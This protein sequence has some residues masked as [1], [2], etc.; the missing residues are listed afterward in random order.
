MAYRSELDGRGRERGIAELRRVYIAPSHRGNGLGRRMVE[1]LIATDHSLMEKT[2]LRPE[3]INASRVPDE[4]IASAVSFNEVSFRLQRKVFQVFQSFGGGFASLRLR[5]VGFSDCTDAVGAVRKARRVKDINRKNVSSIPLFLNYVPLSM[6]VR[7][8]RS[9]LQ[10]RLT[11]VPVRRECPAEWPRSPRYP[12]TSM[13]FR[14]VPSPRSGL[15]GLP[16][17]TDCHVECANRPLG[18]GMRSVLQGATLH[19]EAALSVPPLGQSPYLQVPH[20]T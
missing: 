7:L 16:A 8:W 11:P 18:L 10:D 9:H 14:Y 3:A 19:V 20:R 5:P 17:R 15:F 13:Q 4:T 2:M 12:S 6:C 1:E